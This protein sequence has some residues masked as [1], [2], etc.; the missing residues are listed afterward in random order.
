MIQ[1]GFDVGGTNIKAGIIRDMKIVTRRSARFPK[2]G[3][4]Q[5][6]ADVMESMAYEMLEEQNLN[7]AEIKSIGIAVAGR[8][9]QTSSIVIDAHNLGFHEVPLKAEMTSRFKN[10]PIYLANDANAAALAELH[11]GALIGCKTA[12]LLT[13]GTGIGCGLILDGKMFNGGLGHGV[14]LGHMTLIYDGPSCTCGNKGCVES[15]CA[16]TWLAQEGQKAALKNETGQLYLDADGLVEKISAKTVIDCA[17]QGDA[18]AMEIFDRYIGYLV[19]AITSIAAIFDPEVISIGGGVSLTGSFLFDPLSR[20]VHK[21]S[22]FKYPYKIVP[23]QLGNDAGMI[24]AAMLG[25]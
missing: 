12:V 8:L 25:N 1:I 17:K 19:A 10:I 7:A 11:A 15:V 16:A 13:I 2:E 20:L 4:Y 23:A 6:V 3:P 24:G 18:D 21:N 9:D 22:F 14:E 5:K